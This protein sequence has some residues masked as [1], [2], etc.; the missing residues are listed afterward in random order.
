MSRASTSR[1][2]S[3]RG[4]PQIQAEIRSSVFIAMPVQITAEFTEYGRTMLRWPEI[5]PPVLRCNSWFAAIL[6]SRL[7]ATTDK[8]SHHDNDVRFNSIVE[9]GGEPA[10]S[11]RSVSSMIRSERVWPFLD[12][13]YCSIELRFQLVAQA[14]A[15]FIQPSHRDE[16]IVANFPGVA[17]IHHDRESR[18]CLR[19]CDSVSAE[20]GF[21]R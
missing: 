13:R 6:K 14:I 19:S 4:S 1:R 9:D 17:D 15:T 16:Q 3:Q 7:I 18:I 5:A 10:K 8:Q 12:D 2:G 21:S 11:A 20:S